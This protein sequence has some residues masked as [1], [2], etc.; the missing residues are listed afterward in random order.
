MTSRRVRYPGDVTEALL[1]EV[2][3][4][5][6]AGRRVLVACS[7]G[8]DS[9]VLTHVLCDVAA[10]SGFQV[11]LGHVNHGLRG[12]ESDADERFVVA[13]AATLKVPVRTRR[14]DP[15]ELRKGCSSL[16]RPT[17]QEAARE[18]RYAALVAMAVELDAERIATAHHADDQA[19][20]VL[21]RLMRGSGPDGLGG[22]PERSPDGRLVRP[23]LSVSRAQLEAFAHRHG[24]EWREDRSNAEG[25]YARNRLR[26]DWLP[27]LA[28]EFNPR[29]LRAIGD[30]AE[31]QRR[32]SEWIRGRVESE[33]AARFS[34]EGP[35]LR[36]DAKD[37][38]GMPEALARRLAREALA[39]SGAGRLATRVHLQR[40]LAFFRGAQIGKRIELPGDLTLSRDQVGFQL[41]PLRGTRPD[42]PRGAC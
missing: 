41:G 18:L 9:T 25:D 35:W 30:L 7:G 6:L 11:C 40:M 39:R 12:E 10:Q 37:W 27:G 2:E 21:L 16:E 26:R 22:I 38:I 19:E 28:A 20:T 23:L 3:A 36:I 32:D 29:L 15:G 8:L 13:L 33:A 5:E 34:I 14:V 4:L 31:A 17:L 1:R 24:V 42:R